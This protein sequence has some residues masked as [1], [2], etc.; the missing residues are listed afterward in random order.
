MRRLKWLTLEWAEDDAKAA[1]KV[2]RLQAR[3]QA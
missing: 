3:A 2:K 1:E